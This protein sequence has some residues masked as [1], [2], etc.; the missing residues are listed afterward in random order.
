MCDFDIKHGIVNGPTPNNKP[1]S[2]QYKQSFA[3][4]TFR[5]R[6]PNTL[7]NVI[8]SL[9]QVKQQNDFNSS[10]EEI[11]NI[12]QHVQELKQQMNDDG[13]LTVFEGNGIVFL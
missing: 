8:K 1:L 9:E 11:S 2:G 6:L 5:E 13:P 10:Q 3:Y 12:I 4:Y 7:N